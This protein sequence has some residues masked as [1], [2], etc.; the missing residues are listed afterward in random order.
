MAEQPKG[1]PRIASTPGAK[2]GGPLS[3]RFYLICLACVCVFLVL[4]VKYADSAWA[5]RI[6]P[7]QMVAGLLIAIGLEVRALWKK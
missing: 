7:I 2:T 1:R 4:R 6:A 3:F 5:V